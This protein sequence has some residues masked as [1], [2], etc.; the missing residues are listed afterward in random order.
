LTKCNGKDTIFLE[1]NKIFG[2]IFMKKQKKDRLYEVMNA[3]GLTDYRVYTDVPEITKN[4]MVKLRNGETKDASSRLLEP[5]CKYY[6]QVNPS[7]ILTG[8]GSMLTSGDQTINAKGSTITGSNNRTI[9]VSSHEKSDVSPVRSYLREELVN[10]PYVPIDAKASFVESLYETTYDMDTYGVMSENGEDL[11]SGEYVVFQINGDSMLQSVPSMSKVL[12]KR[13]PEE[14]WESAEGV[15]FIVYGK[16]L[17]VKRILK[18]SLYGKNVL[19]LKADNAAYGQMDVE[20]SEIRG[21]WQAIRI[22]SM[23]IL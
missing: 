19:I 22:V 23:K 2:G 1:T 18:N 6:R 4:M 14:K 12:A 8:E 3:L 9:N 21:M 13:I 20:R 10:V 7:Y 15:V 16:T 11:S 17:T 5:F